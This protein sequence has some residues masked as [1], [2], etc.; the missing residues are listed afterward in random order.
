MS[1]SLAWVQ[2]AGNPR[3]ICSECEWSYPLPTLLT[4]PDARSAFDRLASARFEKHRCTDHPKKSNT[5][6]GGESLSDRARKFIAHGYK[7]KDAVQLILDEIELEYRH[8]PSVLE[9]ARRE[10]EDFLRK[11]RQGQI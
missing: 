7:P 3:W 2:D 11:L 10:A 6:P 1:R 5:L 4:D 9:K 8:Q